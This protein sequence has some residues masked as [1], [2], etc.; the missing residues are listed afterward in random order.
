MACSSASRGSPH[1]P[2]G[3]AGRAR[4]CRVAGVR[5]ASRRRCGVPHRQVKR[6]I[7]PAIGGMPT[8][9][10]AT[11]PV[12]QAFR[13]PLRT[14]GA[15]RVTSSS[16]DVRGAATGRA[17]C[18]GPAAGCAR[19][20]CPGGAA[21]GR[22]DG[23]GGVVPT[24]PP[25]RTRAVSADR[26]GRSRIPGVTTPA[27]RRF[28]PAGGPRHPCGPIRHRIVAT[29]DTRR[30]P[31]NPVTQRHIKPPPPSPL[32]PLCSAAFPA[33]VTWCVCCVCG[34]RAKDAREVCGG[35]RGAMRITQL[36]AGSWVRGWR[37]FP[38]RRRRAV[39]LCDLWACCAGVTVCGRQVGRSAESAGRRGRTSAGRPSGRSESPP[40][41]GAR[42]VGE[43]AA[44]GSWQGGVGRRVR[45][46]RVVSGCRVR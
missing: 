20:A 41:R 37:R 31:P 15:V 18:V 33:T 13:G 7:G 36:R 30:Q 25:G 29:D 45:E 10:C 8:R 22:A 11:D 21:T 32:H 9:G 26:P 2:A 43:S 44:S 16:G 39:T 17:G 14:G 1:G 4:S 27:G 24:L 23:V 40:C 46:C 42:R 5:A 12:D 19:P 38:I 35:C 28:R 3:G 6:K 34:S